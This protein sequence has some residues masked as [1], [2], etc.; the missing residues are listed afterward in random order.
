MEVTVA[1]DQAA[2]DAGRAG[3]RGDGDFLAV[4]GKLVEDLED[5]CPAAFGVRET[6]SSMSSEP[7]ISSAACEYS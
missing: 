6:A 4:R 2:V 1:V 3:D 5:P 7:S